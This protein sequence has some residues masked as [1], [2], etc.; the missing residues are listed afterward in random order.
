VWLAFFAWAEALFSAIFTT[1]LLASRLA[2]IKAFPYTFIVVDT[3]TDAEVAGDGLAFA[4]FRQD[5]RCN[6]SR[7]P[8]QEKGT[9]LCRTLPQSDF[10]I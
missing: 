8:E 3:C 9:V 4:L 7:A 2:V 10:G 5:A 6:V 1:L